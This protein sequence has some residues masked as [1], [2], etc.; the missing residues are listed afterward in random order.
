MKHLDTFESRQVNKHPDDYMPVDAIAEAL[1]DLPLFGWGDVL[2]AAVLAAARACN[3]DTTDLERVGEKCARIIYI[4]HIAGAPETEAASRARV[5][6]AGL[7][8]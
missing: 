5:V 1:A 2:G 4:A 6:H 8:K 7:G 3:V